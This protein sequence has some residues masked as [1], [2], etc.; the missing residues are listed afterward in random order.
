MSVVTKKAIG[1][2]MAN[3]LDSLEEIKKKNKK[4]KHAIRNM[5]FTETESERNRKSE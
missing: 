3:K 4:T 1:I 5:P 2:T